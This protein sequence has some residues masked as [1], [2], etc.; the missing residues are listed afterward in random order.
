[1]SSTS[2]PASRPSAIDLAEEADFAIGPIQVRPSLREVSCD[3][4]A[5]G[6]EPRA[7][8]VLVALA[9]S[10]GNVVSRDALVARCWGGRIVGDDAIN[11][12]VAKARTLADLAQP[13]AFE[14]E[15]IARVGYRLKAL[16]RPLS[17]TVLPPRGRHSAIAA[18]ALALLGVAATA[19]YLSWPRPPRW[20]IVHSQVLIST[21]LMESHPA[22]SPDGTMLAYSA[23]PDPSSR[24]IYLRRIAGG[25]SLKLT[26]DD[27]DD[28]SPSWSPDGSSLAYTTFKEGEPCHVMVSLVPAGPPHEVARCKTEERAQ[29]LWPRSGG[30]LFLRDRLNARSPARLYRLDLETGKRLEITHPPPGTDDDQSFSLSPDGRWVSFRRE[31]DRTTAA[32]WLADL[33][34]GAE[35]LVSDDSAFANGAWSEDSSALLLLSNGGAGDYGIWSVPT[36][37]GRP[38][39]L[40]ANTGEIFRLA[41]GP[42]GLLAAEAPVSKSE[43]RSVSLATGAT[44]V[45]EV[46]NKGQISVPMLAPKSAFTYAGV[47]FGE[48]GIWSRA[49]DGRTTKIAALQPFGDDQFV[50]YSWSPD[51]TKLVYVPP[52]ERVQSVRIIDASG[53]PVSAAAFPGRDVSGP[54]WSA[55]GDAVLFALR[56]MKGWRIWRLDVSDPKH[57]APITGYGW[58]APLSD[59]GALYA[60]RSETGG[61]WRMSDPPM[62][63]T[64]GPTAEHWG[65]ALIRNGE[66]LYVEYPHRQPPR[67][68]AQPIAGGALHTIAEM[69]DYAASLGW[70]YDRESGTLV[71]CA[72]RDD[73]D[74]ALLQLTRK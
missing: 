61:V 34:S 41:A 25:E 16:D 23:G 27:K 13:P 71:Y 65:D 22:I 10:A 7:M 51:G 44:S 5:L 33:Q 54:S 28:S 12:A 42:R 72:N 4:R 73:R 64:A 21:P 69:P 48:F 62:R 8:Q 47:R 37:G 26:D 29:V 57:P 50:G 43:L 70:D 31:K 38:T 32:I 3:G 49:R 60:V 1:M 55:D 14:I 2:A 18:A 56:D 20:E 59:G 74:I 36:A 24:S 15:A 11:R 9:Q 6:V 17:A 63:I 66:I 53:L 58:E 39:Q 68:V 45:I 52:S 67:L 40:T 35:R 30:G 46:A 19:G